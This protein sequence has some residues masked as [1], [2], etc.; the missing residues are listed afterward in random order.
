MQWESTKGAHGLGWAALFRFKLG[1]ILQLGPIN[2]WVRLELSDKK[3]KARLGRIYLTS[4][5][6]GCVQK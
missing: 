6:H 4:I 2:T 1:L 3:F 5:N